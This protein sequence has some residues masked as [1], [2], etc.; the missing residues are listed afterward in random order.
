M[1]SQRMGV[2]SA[3]TGCRAAMTVVTEESVDS[4]LSSADIGSEAATADEEEV[5]EDVLGCHVRSRRLD[6]SGWLGRRLAVLC[7][8]VVRNDRTTA[9]RDTRDP[10]ADVT[11]ALHALGTHDT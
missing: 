6:Q 2:P 10:T 11:C 3:S 9:V 7:L 4:V 1:P 5:A 8:R